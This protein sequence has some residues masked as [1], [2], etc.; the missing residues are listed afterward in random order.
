ML[1]ALN[2]LKKYVDLSGV[3]TDE[4][5]RLIGARLV[6]VE[7]VV[8]QR[9]KYENI[10]VVKVVSAE[11]I[12][13]THLT[14]C[15]IDDAGVAKKI[16][17]GEDRL[18]QVMCGAPNV[19]A[20]M[21]AVWIA[22]GAV[23]PASVN[24]DAPFVIGTRKMLGKY[25]SHGMLAGADE[26]D[27][28]NEHKTI[29][30]ISPDDAKAG[31]PFG[32]LFGLEDIILE[33]ENKSLTHRPDTFGI[34]GFAREVAGILGQKFET[35][36]WLMDFGEKDFATENV[37]LKIK[38]ADGDICPRYTALIMEGKGDKKGRYLG[39][40]ETLLAR[41]G[42]RPVSPLV[43][44]TNY[45]MLLTG[46]PLHAFDYD[47]LV[48][49]GGRGGPEIIVRLAKQGEELELLDGKMIKLVSSDIVITSSD[50]PIALAG[51]MGGKNTEIDENTRKIIVESATFSLYN[52]RKTQMVHGIFSEAITRFTKGQ[53]AGQTLPVVKEF[54]GL[55]AGDMRSLGLVD[56]WVD[57][58]KNDVVKVAVEQVNGL[59]GTEY[60]SELV[61]GT[62]ERVGFEVAGG[63]FLENGAG[64]GPSLRAAAMS[65]SHPSLR[66]AKSPKSSSPATSLAVTVPYWRTDIRIPEDIIEEVGR[67][68][69]YDNIL[70][71]VPLHG[72]AA[73][74]ELFVLKARVREVLAGAGANELLTYSFIHGDLMRKV[75]Q[76]VKN[77]YRVVNSISPDLQYVRQQ[78][79]PSLLVKAAENLKD[80]FGEFG[81]FEMNQVFR[82]DLGMDEE[83]V[84]ILGN[85]LAFVYAARERKSCFYRAKKY[86]MYLARRLGVEL[87]LEQ[88]MGKG[89]PQ[90][91]A[92]YE[93]RR[94]AKV[95]VGDEW[96]GVI[97]E[98]K[99]SVAHELK[100][101]DGTAMFEV[102]MNTLIGKIDSL[103]KS[104]KTSQYPSVERDITVVAKSGVSY[105]KVEGRI[106]KLLGDQELM[107]KITP[108]AIYQ[109]E[110]SDEQKVSFHLEF[111]DKQKTL[112]NEE[113]QRI[114]GLLEQ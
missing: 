13:D 64:A 33:I 79:V 97:G 24:E 74:N 112:A 56:E 76:D 106:A 48:A 73:A 38:L 6:E 17:R 60:S 20:G 28:G 46:Q 108:T 34:I 67:I 23:V 99:K 84:P 37:D 41:S 31:M 61:M 68:N 95:M 51:A 45:L 63:D 66:I 91:E 72:T 12:P 49:V 59:L 47:K 53:P 114:M 65:S 54:A 90:Y 104:F 75:G 3:G 100:L 82:R 9:K 35:P 102:G 10:F 8:D 5:I 83:D 89:L 103:E 80:G 105:E 7:G 18:I 93:P 96:V 22:P 11:K 15:K 36:E 19:R 85:N 42:M 62:L 70:S 1:I 55:L 2:W 30:E 98:V 92:F 111:A 69:G 88:V 87:R 4:L 50:R 25:E 113:I 32:Q 27:F 39:E 58:Q 40:I 81:V 78:I 101:P 94:S 77:S 109:A 43:D 107:Y 110:N 14:L 26:L 71:R 52:L 21:L 29:A 86:L 44:M 16:S 57:G